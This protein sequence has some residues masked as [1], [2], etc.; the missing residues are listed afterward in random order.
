MPCKNASASQMNWCLASQPHR[1]RGYSLL[2]TPAKEPPH[3]RWAS[4]QERDNYNQKYLNLTR[5]D[6]Y[7]IHKWWTQQVLFSW[8]Y[9]RLVFISDQ[10]DS[11]ASPRR[12]QSGS[13]NSSS[14]ELSPY[15]TL[16]FPGSPKPSPPT[17]QGQKPGVEATKGGRLAF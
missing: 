5:E 15:S 2:G 14:P 13:S 10:A 17:V 16:T 9:N 8:T 12:Q 11:P 6:T 7:L 3:K 4:N 1:L